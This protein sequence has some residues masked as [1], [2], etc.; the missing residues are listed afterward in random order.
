MNW[1]RGLLDKI[2][3]W[4]DGKCYRCVYLYKDSYGNMCQSKHGCVKE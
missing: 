2:V 4:D 3:K 1:F